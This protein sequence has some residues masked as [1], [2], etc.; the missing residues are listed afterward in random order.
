MRLRVENACFGY[1]EHPVLRDVSVTFEKG[2]LTGII[3][4]NGSGKT[5]LI[6]LMSGAIRPTSGT[7]LLDGREIREYSGKKLSQALSVVPQKSQLEFDFTVLD[8]V[9][10]GRQP[11]IGRFGQ[12]SAQDLALARQALQLTGVDHLAKRPVTG[13][14]GG[15]WQRVIIARAL[16]QS[17]PAMLLD[18]PVSS[19]DIRHQLEVLSLVRRLAHQR[20]VAAVCVL[21]DLNL[22]AH[23]CDELVMMNAGQLV[24]QGRP[25]QVLTPEQLRAVYGIE[26]RVLPEADGMVSVMPVYC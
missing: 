24:A 16:C 2:R 7:V 17:T 4:P 20:K 19:L 9:L 13:L 1:E 6:K 26:A 8:V 15:E 22:A 14:S 18:E 21:H 11:Y 5:T 25:D 12:E 10:M 23:Y 3:G